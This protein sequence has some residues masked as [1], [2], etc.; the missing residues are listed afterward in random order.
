MSKSLGMGGHTRF[1]VCV[2][3]WIFYFLGPPDFRALPAL[4]QLLL[5]EDLKN[6]V[7]S[8]WVFEAILDRRGHT[9]PIPGPLEP[10]GRSPRGA[11]R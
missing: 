4:N 10:L 6:K 5:L 1:S 7:S 3:A 8:V 11:D 9:Y 2:R